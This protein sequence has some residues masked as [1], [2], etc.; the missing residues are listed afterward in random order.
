MPQVSAFI[1]A[2]SWPK[3]VVSREIREPEANEGTFYTAK[4]RVMAVIW[5]AAAPSANLA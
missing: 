3:L 4:A 1:T 2:N 5:S